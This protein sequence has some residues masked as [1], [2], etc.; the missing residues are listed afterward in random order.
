MGWWGAHRGPTLRGGGAVQARRAGGA[1]PAQDGGARGGPVPCC[2]RLRLWLL[3]HG[4]HLILLCT[5]PI[6]REGEWRVSTTAV[7]LQ[8]YTLHIEDY[9]LTPDNNWKDVTAA[10][11][12]AVAT[13]AHTTTALR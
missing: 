5:A 7:V 10:Y 2:H 9:T 13:H 1:V 3:L 6:D 12:I 11:K 8:D 4:L